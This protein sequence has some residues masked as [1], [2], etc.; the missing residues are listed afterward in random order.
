MTKKSDYNDLTAQISKSIAQSEKRLEAVKIELKTGDTN[1]VVALEKEAKSIKDSIAAIKESAVTLKTNYEAYRAYKNKPEEERSNIGMKNHNE[2][3]SQSI[4]LCRRNL[5]IN[6][7]ILEGPPPV[8][9]Q[10]QN[11]LDNHIDELSVLKQKIQSSL[12]HINEIKKDMKKNNLNDKDKLISNA[13]TKLIKE[14][15][16]ID[17][18]IKEV[19]KYINDPVRFSKTMVPSV[20]EQVIFIKS[21]QIKYE[22]KL[23][24]GAEERLINKFLKHKPEDL[25]DILESSKKIELK[26]SDM[27]GKAVVLSVL[28]KAINSISAIEKF[29]EAQ[30]NNEVFAHKILAEANQSVALFEK[31]SKENPQYISTADILKSMGWNREMAHEAQQKLT[32]VEPKETQVKLSSIEKQIDPVVSASVEAKNGNVDEKRQFFED[33]AEKQSNNSF[34]PK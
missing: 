4:G 10:L 17:N 25:E 28:A 20:S 23:G 16:S 2:S 32:D 29:E 19:N 9:L 14:L 12:E 6:K 30:K 24:L 34:R 15:S 5:A 11:K 7:I 31:N 33:L 22:S 3:L 13:E 18:Q 8:Y 1:Q 27:S 26:T 21:L